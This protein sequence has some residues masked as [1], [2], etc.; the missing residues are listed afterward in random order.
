MTEYAMYRRDQ[1]IDHDDNRQKQR[2]ATT[3]EL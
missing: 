1:F 3:N 2:G